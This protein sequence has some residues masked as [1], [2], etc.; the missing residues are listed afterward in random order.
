M[1]VDQCNGPQLKS[2]ST[3]LIQRI[4]LV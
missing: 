3:F 1:A 2:A 4:S